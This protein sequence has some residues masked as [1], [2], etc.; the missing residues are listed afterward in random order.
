MR[1]NR[2]RADGSRPWPWPRLCTLTIRTRPTANRAPRR[3][4]RSSFARRRARR[5]L[6]TRRMPY[7]RECVRIKRRGK[8]R[9]TTE[10]SRARGPCV[11]PPWPL[12][13]STAQ[14]HGY[15]STQKNGARVPAAA[16]T[17]HR[18][19]VRRTPW[20][21]CARGG[22]HSRAECREHASARLLGRGRG[23]GRWAMARPRAHRHVRVCSLLWR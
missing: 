4:R 22:G 6:S 10:R 2:G 15:K 13:P 5:A 9:Q 1:R 19:R 21:E 11:H 18:E 14:R 16:R 20:C 17:L 7:E 23:D 12:P 8:R 3:R